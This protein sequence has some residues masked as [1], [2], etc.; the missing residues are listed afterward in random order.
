MAMDENEL[1]AVVEALQTCIRLQ[2]GAWQ[3]VIDVARKYAQ[4]KANGTL[5]R[6]NGSLIRFNHMAAE[7]QLK[8][9]EREL[10]NEVEAAF[11]EDAQVGATVSNHLG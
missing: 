7:E 5:I 2:R 11:T 1:K 4:M 10:L 6:P 8:Q 3:R 9:L